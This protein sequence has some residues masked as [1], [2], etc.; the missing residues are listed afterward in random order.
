MGGVWFRKIYI[1]KHEF[2]RVWNKIS[3]H[4]GINYILILA[5]CFKKIHTV[6]ETYIVNLH[7]MMQN[8]CILIAICKHKIKSR[9]YSQLLV[10]WL[11]GHKLLYDKES[12]TFQK[13]IFLVGNIQTRSKKFPNSIFKYLYGE[14][15][16]L[17][18]FQHFQSIWISLLMVHWYY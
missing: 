17:W 18:S 12:S 15:Y 9:Y 1:F 7:T 5:L 2:C 6:R 13:E 8:F 16:Y 11:S 4:W 10:K 3:N 14:K